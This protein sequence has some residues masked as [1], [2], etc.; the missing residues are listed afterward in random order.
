[1]KYA[2][3]PGCKIAHH[4]PEYGMSV[5]A[6]CDVLGIE[7][8]KME[9]NC[10]GWPVRHENELASIFSA[11]RNFA[12]A[13][14][15]GLPML[16]P[17]KCCFGNLKYAASRMAEDG[18]IAAQV[19][20]L[21]GEE[22]LA[23][24]KT[25]DVSH[26]LTVLDQDIGPDR[27][28]TLTKNSLKGVKVA[29]H[30]GCHALRPSTVTGFDDPLAPTVFERV[31]SSIGAEPVDWD[32]RLECCGHPLR[33]RDDVISAELMRKKLEDAENVGADVVATAC[34]YCQMQFDKERDALSNHHPLRKAP[35]AVLVTQLIGK[36]LDIDRKALGMD[37]NR[38]PWFRPILPGGSL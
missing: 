21:L 38:I 10:C 22:G 31:L 20:E 30:Y 12:L 9:F 15:A 1:M 13:K 26:L 24:P 4:L 7:L 37:K 16:T 23:L 25:M 33:G 27:L 35:P 18:G 17:C 6:V 3:F 14:A 32:L 5:E 19:A 8:V 11:V 34:T 29:C 28:K 36:A 2:Y